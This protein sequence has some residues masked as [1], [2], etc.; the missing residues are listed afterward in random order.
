MID[1]N[2][3]LR[4]EKMPPKEIN[5]LIKM[6]QRIFVHFLKIKGFPS[7]LS[8]NI[9]LLDVVDIIS[10]V[11]KRKAYYRCFHNMEINECKTAALYAYWFLKFRPLQITDVRYINK[12][13]ICNINEAFAIHLIFY[14]LLFTGRIT[15]TPK[16]NDSFY[17]LLE[18]SFRFRNFS[19]DAFIVLVESITTES[20]ERDYPDLGYYNQ[21]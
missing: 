9:S 6:F 20:F 17:K 11:D 7:D 16:S 14:A 13:E 3:S 4:Y 18:Y 15:Q 8:F 5:S 10:R 19:I 2:A 21:L 12:H 1:R